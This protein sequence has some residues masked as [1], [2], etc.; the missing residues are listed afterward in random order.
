[1]VLIGGIDLGEYILMPK[2]GMTM[3]TGRINQ[4]LVK[5]GDKVQKGDPLF[6][7][8]TDKTALEVESLFEGYILKIYKGSDEE[9]AI[10]QPVAYMGKIGEVVPEPTDSTMQS[11]DK[12]V[13]SEANNKAAEISEPAK[14]PDEMKEEKYDTDLVIIGGGPG[15]YVAAIRAA[16][17]GGK[18]ILIEKEKVGG[19]CLNWGCIPTKAMVRNAEI[20]RYVKNSEDMGISVKEATLDWSKV[21]QRK[22]EVVSKLV[23]GVQALLRKNKVETITDIGKVTRNEV[24]EVT[25]KDGRKR[26]IKTKNIIL[27]TG[28]VPT[29]I[30]VETS[31][32]VKILNTNSIFDLNKL[33]KSMAIIGGGVVGAEFASI[34]CTFGVKVTIIELM[35]TILSTID[36]EI[37]DFMQKQFVKDGIDIFTSRKVTKILKNKSNTSVELDDGT[38]IEVDEILMAVGRKIENGAFEGFNLNSDKRGFLTVNNIMQTSVANIYAIGDIT[39]KL[40]LA[41][42]ASEQ[43]IIAVENIFGKKSEMEYEV[44]PSC[45]FT[46]PEIASVGIT[47][48]QAK[49]KNIPYKAT[50]FSFQANGKALTLGH[51]EGFVKVI[52]DMRWGEILGVHIVGPEASNLIQEAVMAMKLEGTVEDLAKTIHAHPTLSE[53]VMEAALNNLGIAIHI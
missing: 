41:H 4:W 21:L 8:E 36:E 24:V 29:I 27:A 42:V 25:T 19:T 14:K 46:Y 30:N 18:V 6:E 31:P 22:T 53:A 37:A 43:G 5:E 51:S 11:D 44:I 7:V 40:Q 28:T 38:T 32:D 45:I 47:E 17:L 33:P 9:A 39:G 2:L 48:K 34:F 20:W 3:E 26:E 12:K 49:E 16:Q 1:M 10:N 23:G 15:G 50:K 35:P 13:E 52:A